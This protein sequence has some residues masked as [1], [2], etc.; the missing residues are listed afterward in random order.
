[1]WA[2][3]NGLPVSIGRIS[4]DIKAVRMP[5]NSASLGETRGMTN[6]PGGI[7]SVPGCLGDSRGSC[8]MFSV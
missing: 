4:R 1:M 7:L 6:R 5:W 3:G 2:C 8:T